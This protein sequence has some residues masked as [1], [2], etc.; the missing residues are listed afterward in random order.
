MKEECSDNKKKLK[1][2]K[3]KDQPIALMT[4]AWTIEDTDVDIGEYAHHTTSSS[5]KA[6]L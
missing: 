4:A 1:K 5:Q 2:N 3:M 6:K